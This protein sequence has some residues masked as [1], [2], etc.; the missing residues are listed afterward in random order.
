MIPL[1]S[2]MMIFWKAGWVE[3]NMIEIIDR[4]LEFKSYKKYSEA[5]KYEIKLLQQLLNEERVSKAYKAVVKKF[6]GNGAKYV[7]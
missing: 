2:W 6:T 5:L 4:E 7:G 3:Y 1:K